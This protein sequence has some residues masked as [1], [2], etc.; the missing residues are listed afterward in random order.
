MPF[1]INVP[2]EMESDE[3]EWWGLFTTILFSV[4]TD[5]FQNWNQWDEDESGCISTIKCKVKTF[6]CKI[7]VH[8]I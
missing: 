8:Q 5:V 3:D 4:M 7:F 2:Q 1:G 6:S